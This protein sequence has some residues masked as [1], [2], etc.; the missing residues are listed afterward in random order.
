MTAEEY[1]KTLPDVKLIFAYIKCVM[2]EDIEG[3]E[4]MDV[5]INND[6]YEDV[7]DQVDALIEQARDRAFVPYKIETKSDLMKYFDEVYGEFIDGDPDIKEYKKVWMID[8]W[9]EFIDSLNEMKDYY[10][11]ANWYECDGYY[12]MVGVW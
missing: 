4:D 8:P 3:T 7:K 12:F 10:K 6:E 11:N 9:K 1:I 5:D 2:S